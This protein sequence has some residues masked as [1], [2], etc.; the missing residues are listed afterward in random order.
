MSSK[1][2][3]TG[4]KNQSNL[5][6]VRALRPLVKAWREDGYKGVSKT[7]RRLLEWWFL[8]EHQLTNGS[9]FVFWSAQIDAIEHFIFCHEVLQTRSLYQLAQKLDVHIPIDPSA[10]KWVKYAFKMATG[11]GK[12][13][14]MA[15]AIVWSYFNAIREKRSDFS[16]NFVL[17]APNL[18]VLDRLMGDS[19]SPEFFEGGIFKKYPFLPPEWSSD[20]QLD[21]I[22]P[23]E[24]RAST[25]ASTL[26]LLNWQKFVE[27]E[28]GNAENPVQDILGK[29]PTTEIAITL[30]K[31]KD[32]L[33]QLENVMV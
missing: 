27:R 7:T 31:L 18:I 2:L 12:T 9:S 1:E 17:I 28:N 11:S 4:I 5:P 6:L 23:E 21:V 30:A 15:M 19:K 3:S 22:G 16:K 10:D 25:K 13:M 29:K 32:R 14:I 8:E 20:F 26:Y 33:A 24:E